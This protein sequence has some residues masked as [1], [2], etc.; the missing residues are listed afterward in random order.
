MDFQM[1]S[2][3]SAMV[4]L[5]CFAPNALGQTTTDLNGVI[6]NCATSQVSGQ[7]ASCNVI[8]DYTWCIIA[9]TSYL[10][11]SQTESNYESTLQS[12]VDS[13]VSDLSLSCS[14]TVSSLVPTETAI[15]QTQ[16]KALATAES[17]CSSSFSA[18]N[19]GSATCDD[20]DNYGWC[21]I[22]LTSYSNLGMTEAAYETAIQAYVDSKISSNSAGC[23]TI[24]VSSM[25][26]EPCSGTK[27]AI[28]VLL[29]LMCVATAVTKLY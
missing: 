2:L 6:S 24:V 8:S 21:I 29:I 27:E 15:G 18:V 10:S 14:I 17:T 20:I 12:S 16:D 9:C 13:L 7:T 1:I 19:G 23:T 25:V 22:D 5:V 26:T 4:I 11:L 3:S 28:S